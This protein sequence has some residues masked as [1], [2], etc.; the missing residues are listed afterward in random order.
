MTGLDGPK[1][2]V[3]D[4]GV[5]GMKGEPG[6][7]GERV[8]KIKFNITTSNTVKFKLRLIDRWSVVA[9]ETTALRVLLVR[10]EMKG[11]VDLVVTP[12][13]WDLQDLPEKL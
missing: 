8:R 5:A 2:Q 10:L 12:G 6:F 3:G 11:S 1:G 9:R 4:A 13:L 7:K